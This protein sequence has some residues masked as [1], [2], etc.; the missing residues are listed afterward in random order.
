MVPPNFESFRR[1]G[2]NNFKFHNNSVT[3]QY[4]VKLKMKI[5]Q[6]GGPE[7]QIH[8]MT[9]DKSENDI[10]ENGKPVGKNQVKTI[11]IDLQNNVCD[12]MMTKMTT[13]M[14]YGFFVIRGVRTKWEK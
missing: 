1:G 3:P 2:L 13:A 11:G 12:L 7:N 9:D 6:T 8:G 5:N 14:V 10:L 4:Y